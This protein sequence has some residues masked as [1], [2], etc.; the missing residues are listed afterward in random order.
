MLGMPFKSIGWKIALA[1]GLP[2]AVALLV[3]VEISYQRGNDVIRQNAAQEAAALADLVAESFTLVDSTLAARPGPPALV[4]RQVAAAIGADFKIYDDVTTLR[5]I[6]ADGKVRWS[7]RIEDVGTRLDDAARLL[8]APPTGATNAAKGEYVRP[9]GGMSCARCHTADAFKLGAVQAVIAEP[10]IA[11]DF[12]ELYRGVLVFLGVLCLLLSLASM[13]LLHV[14]ITRP[15][16]RL[17]EVMQRA[18]KGDFLVRA[19]IETGDEI[20]RLA[21]AFNSMVSRI[22]E[23]K[24]AEIET[25]RE[26]ET[27]QRELDLKAELERQHKVIEEANRALARRVRDVTLLLDVARSLNSTLAL[28]EILSMVTEM[29]GVTVGVDQF[30][31]ML[32]DE[33]GSELM[34]AASFGF[35]PGSLSEFRLPVGHGACGLAAK[36]REPVYVADTLTDPRARRTR[37]ARARCWRCR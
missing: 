7:R 34:V 8:K 18:E 10:G 4:H 27:M 9:L 5:V 24:V 11:D 35:K 33:T 20:G 3:G 12:R 19:R 31:V 30:A 14:F 17:T 36:A 2:L 32:L 37:W 6:G 1:I 13:G 21:A 29:V 26:I 25:S 22:T 16:L 23:M 15:I 28:P